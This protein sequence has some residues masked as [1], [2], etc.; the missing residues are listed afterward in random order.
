MSCSLPDKEEDSKEVL[1]TNTPAS[2][3]KSE[4]PKKNVPRLEP[5]PTQSRPTLET[6]SSPP[7][8]LDQ[9][10]Q[11]TLV[12]SSITSKS[13]LIFYFS[14]IWL[15]PIWENTEWHITQPSMVNPVWALLKVQLKLDSININIYFQNNKLNTCNVA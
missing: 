6:A 2:W 9:L 1:S 12:R 8:W 5:N 11:F 10:S 7:R 15:V 13:K 14:S 3:L 4:R